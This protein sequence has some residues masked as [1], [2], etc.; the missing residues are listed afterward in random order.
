MSEDPKDRIEAAMVKAVELEKQAEKVYKEIRSMITK[1]D[2]LPDDQ[3]PK[4]AAIYYA[5]AT[6]LYQLRIMMTK[7]GIPHGAQ[8]LLDIAALEASTAMQRDDDEL[9]DT[10]PMVKKIDKD[11][12]PN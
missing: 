6:V 4:S 12:L 10:I 5:V 7:E 9:P 8:V 1:Y 11:Q 3:R 2:S